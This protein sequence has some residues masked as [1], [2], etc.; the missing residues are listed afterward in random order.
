VHNA[1]LDLAGLP[2][3]QHDCCL[4]EGKFVAPHGCTKSIMRV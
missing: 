2:V 1:S 4:V 3:P